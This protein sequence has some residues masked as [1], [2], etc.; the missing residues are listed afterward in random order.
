MP[1]V[2]AP[3]RY[4]VGIFPKNSVK[5]DSF[6]RERPGRI[7]GPTPSL[8][9]TNNKKRWILSQNNKINIYPQNILGYYSLL[10]VEKLGPRT[11][12]RS[13]LLGRG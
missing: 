3:P 5:I 2:R 6:P 12:K 4:Y 7:V 1:C 9:E 11:L 8:T 10:K 13:R